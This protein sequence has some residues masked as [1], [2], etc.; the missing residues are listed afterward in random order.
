MT[1][2]YRPARG[3]GPSGLRDERETAPTI[4]R[5]P[6]P[7]SRGPALTGTPHRP[8]PPSPTP[9][10]HP[11][12]HPSPVLAASA[13]GRHRTPYP[14]DRS[15]SRAPESR[16][17]QRID[18]VQEAPRTAVTTG[19]SPGRTSV[20][21]PGFTAAPPAFW[22]SRQSW[23]R[24]AR[25]AARLRPPVVRAAAPGDGA[26]S[27]A[28]SNHPITRFMLRVARRFRAHSV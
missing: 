4:F 18:A 17:C 28:F 27:V 26:G 19:P 1:G 2:G 11:A 15:G 22:C 20:A 24:R 3:T 8:P 14:S 25:A 21:D 7:A 9:L 16:G 10:R 12:L 13:P 5:V 6:C 23:P